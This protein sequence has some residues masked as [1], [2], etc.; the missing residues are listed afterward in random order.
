ML[1]RLRDGERGVGLARQV[2]RAVAVGTTATEDAVDS[3]EPTKV[4]PHTVATAPTPVEESDN[5]AR[6]RARTKRRATKGAWLF[7]LVL[8]LAALAGGAGWWFGSGPGSLVAVPDVS[9]GTFADAQARLAQDTLVAVE[10]GVY[11]LEEIG[12]AHV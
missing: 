6:L 3:A 12:R 11:D 7:T 10:E 9:G 8:L 4:L 2:A 5:G 1:A